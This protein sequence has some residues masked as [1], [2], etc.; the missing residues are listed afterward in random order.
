[1]NHIVTKSLGSAD[2]PITAGERSALA[3]LLAQHPR[4]LNRMSLWQGFPAAQLDCSQAIEALCLLQIRRLVRLRHEHL[5]LTRHAFAPT[6]TF[7]GAQ[8]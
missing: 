4:P 8:A 5:Y 6:A 3:A 1:M 2:R 7:T